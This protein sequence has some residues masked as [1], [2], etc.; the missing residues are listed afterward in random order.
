MTKPC[1]AMRVSPS[2]YYAARGRSESTHTQD[3]RRLRVLVQTSFHQSKKRYG[4]PR[5]FEDLIEQGVR[6]SPSAWLG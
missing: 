1:S 2:G 5:V 4:S 6:V 3:D